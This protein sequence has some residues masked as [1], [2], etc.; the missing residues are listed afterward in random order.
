MEDGMVYVQNPGTISM[1]FCTFR[2]ATIILQHVNCSIIQ[3]CEF[4]QTDSA[5]ITVEGYP[6]EDKNWTYRGLSAKIMN[7]CS[8]QKKPE[9][10]KSSDIFIPK[11]AFSLSTA[12]TSYQKSAA[13]SR[14][15]RQISGDTDVE[16]RKMSRDFD[17][18]SHDLDGHV[19]HD[20]N[21]LPVPAVG[22][23]DNR[24]F[25]RRQSHTESNFSHNEASLYEDDFDIQSDLHSSSKQ[26]K[27]SVLGTDKNQ[28]GPSSKHLVSVKQEKG[29]L[30]H[31]K[32]KIKRIESFVT[33]CA[34]YSNPGTSGESTLEEH[35]F[36]HMDH[37]HAHAKESES[38]GKA[39]LHA[40]DLDAVKSKE[41]NY[42]S[43]ESDSESDI[44]GNNS[45]IP[46]L[47]L[48]SVASL[49]NQDNLGNEASGV[50]NDARA[51]RER[52]LSSS[53]VSI[54][55]ASSDDVS[56]EEAEPGG[57]NSGNILFQ[58]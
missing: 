52:S 2:H 50:N 40:L 46:P 35:D 15:Q 21:V 32:E 41:H 45:N 49:S 18:Q 44:N 48:H 53:E 22:G 38:Q 5:A 33:D 26:T 9:P 7:Y 24:G 20:R 25:H 16:H 47:D 36:D 31:H 27:S 55:T 10:R 12:T 3:N 54:H 39:D 28:P 6:K 56:S 4:S 23:T 58:I 51:Q 14:F 29:D 30:K 1:S 34:K 43:E 37:F 57:Y 13:K 17:Q 42:Y 19:I 11:S 8:L